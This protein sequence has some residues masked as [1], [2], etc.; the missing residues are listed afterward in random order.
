MRS[1]PT[2]NAFT[3]SGPPREDL[4]LRPDVDRPERGEDRGDVSTGESPSS[5]NRR[6][7]SCFSDTRSA[8]RC[9]FIASCAAPT[10]PRP[11]PRRLTKATI[12]KGPFSYQRLAELRLLS[13]ANATCSARGRPVGC[14]YDRSAERSGGGVPRSASATGRSSPY[15]QLVGEAVVVLDGPLHVA[16]VEHDDADGG[17]GAHGG[18]AAVP[19]PLPHRLHHRQRH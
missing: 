19:H 17:E 3:W 2:L 16:L 6:R 12:N 4:K 15:L 8:L 9:R 13:F 10:R 7:A 14:G 11:R 18:G 1:A 5:D